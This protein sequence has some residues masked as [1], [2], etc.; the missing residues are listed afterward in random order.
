MAL[1]SSPQLALDACITCKP[2]HN[3]VT[4]HEG[5][6]DESKPSLFNVLR[7][8]LSSFSC[9]TYYPPYLILAYLC[10]CTSQWYPSLSIQSTYS[11]SASTF[12]NQQPLP[13]QPPQTIHISAGFHNGLHRRLAQLPPLLGCL[14]LA[15]RF[16]LATPARRNA[17]QDLAAVMRR[18]V[19]EPDVWRT[20]LSWGCSARLPARRVEILMACL[21]AEG[22]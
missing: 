22:L 2:P 5:R 17:C 4:K 19:D 14:L 20:R 3:T 12:Q 10:I 13:F 1:P 16:R 6:S 18:E 15:A 8:M 21:M 7:C 9:Y 11:T